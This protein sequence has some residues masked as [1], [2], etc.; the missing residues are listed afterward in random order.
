M[1]NKIPVGILGATGAVGQNYI[2]LLKDHPWFE[3][4]WVAA[5]PRSAGKKYSEAVA[6]RWLH[7]PDIPEGVRDLLVYD[8]NNALNAEGKCRFVFSALEL[9]S[10]DAIREL[11]NSYA[12]LHIPVISNASAHRWTDN[13]PMLI[14]EI[15]PDHISVIDE[16]KK[17]HGWDRGFVAVKP[18]CS[19]QS[20][21]TPVYALM[22][23]GYDV[24]R[25]FV[26]TMQAVSGAGYPGV[27]SL[28]MIDNVVP[29][30]GGEEEKSE[31]EPLKILGTVSGGKIVNAS[32]P[33]ITAHCNRVPVTNGHTACVS[34][35][36]GE[37]KPSLEEIEKIWTEFR[38]LPQELG[39]PFAPKQPIIVRHEVNRPQPQRDRDA[40]KAMA[41]SVGRLRADPVFDI[42]FVGLSH[43]TV[44]GAAGGGIMNAELLKAKGYLV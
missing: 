10:K 25:L 34:L 38:G 18:N 12:A 6:N 16:Q 21:M 27:P 28:D 39:L 24:K 5:S 1:S 31:Q 14:P 41:V 4:T 40:D 29:Y 37:K 11:E 8:A 23:A 19:L 17:M 22:K 32:G 15:N 35:E 26:A 36:F 7:G 3:V 30:I 43:N 9:D 44:R 13:V 2:F 33:L 20:Y 42:R